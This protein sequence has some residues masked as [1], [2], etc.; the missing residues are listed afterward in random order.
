MLGV[1]DQVERVSSADGGPKFDNTGT[2]GAFDAGNEEEE[3][4]KYG[5]GTGPMAKKVGEA[6]GE[7][8]SGVRDG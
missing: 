6:V 5:D 8:S 7:I 2:S 1:E 4:A 3:E